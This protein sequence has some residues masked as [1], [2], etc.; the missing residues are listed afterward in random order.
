MENIAIKSFSVDFKEKILI[1]ETDG[2]HIYKFCFTQKNARI[3]RADSMKKISSQALQRMQIAINL[4]LKTLSHLGYLNN[5][6]Y[7]D[8][9][10]RANNKS[11]FFK[12]FNI[13]DMCFECDYGSYDYEEIKRLAKNSD[14]FYDNLETILTNEIIKK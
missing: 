1:V 4:E 14:T 13:D 12:S 10:F 2:I 6:T 11:I 3:I 9:I 7:K 5:L 8:G